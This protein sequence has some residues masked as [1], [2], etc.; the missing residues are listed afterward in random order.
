MGRQEL[1]VSVD[2]GVVDPTPWP[3]ALELIPRD[4]GGALLQD[5]WVT[6]RGWSPPSIR[7]DAGHHD[8]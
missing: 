3:E 2:D 5:H 4:D 8:L 7:K 6:I 1:A